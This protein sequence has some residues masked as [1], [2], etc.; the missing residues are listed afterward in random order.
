M[1]YYIKLISDTESQM[2]LYIINMLGH[3]FPWKRKE[4]EKLSTILWNP[5]WTSIWI[6]YI[7]LKIKV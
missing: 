6:L 4:K 3:N 7:L 2:L 1:W 5:G